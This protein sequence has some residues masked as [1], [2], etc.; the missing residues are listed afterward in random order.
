MILN[1]W[2]IILDSKQ[3]K[4]NVP[5]GIKRFNHNLVLWRNNDK[6]SCL[7]DICA[8]RGSAL[9]IG[10]INNGNIQCPFHGIEYN[11]Y[12]KCTIIPSDGKFKEPPSNFKVKTYEVK[13]SFGYIWIWHGDKQENYPDIHFFPEN[14][15]DNSFSY[16]QFIDHWPVH[17]S[18][19]IEN[20]LDCQHVPFVHRNT[21]GRGNKTLVN[22]PLVKLDKDKLYMWVFN[23]TDKGQKPLKP[24]DLNI[25]MKK[26]NL[27]FVFPNLWMNNINEKM[28][29]TASFVPVD[30]ENTIIYLRYYQKIIT[31]PIIKNIFLFTGKLFSKK[32]LRQDKRVVITQVP[33]KSELIM[34]TENLTQADLPIINYRKIRNSLKNK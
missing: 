9:S 28:K 2:Y 30:E 1:Q 29:V 8:H 22:G 11:S 6:I 25:N 18:R 12:G 13:D 10:K 20:Q 17:Y 3:L 19:A 21:I 33:K 7:E 24:G 16:S 34:N 23:E 5:I 14:L 4:N 26:F 31:I 15:L 27:L 32:I